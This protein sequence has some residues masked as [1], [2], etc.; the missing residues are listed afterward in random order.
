MLTCTSSLG[1]LAL[2]TGAAAA[3]VAPAATPRSAASR[4][5]AGVHMATEVT[6]GDSSRKSLLAGIDAVANAVKVTLGP[7][8]RNVVLELSLIHI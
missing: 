4:A 6:F 5:A 7:K 2:A 3:Y 1:L 8:G